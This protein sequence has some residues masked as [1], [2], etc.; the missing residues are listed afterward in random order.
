MQFGPVEVDYSNA[1]SIC[2]SGDMQIRDGFPHQDQLQP[3]ATR[4]SYDEIFSL[5][6]PVY[7]L[8]PSPP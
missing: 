6:K 2:I 7:E 8:T 3:A 5:G 1:H 4:C